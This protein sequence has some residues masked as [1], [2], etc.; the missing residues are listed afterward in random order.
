MPKDQSILVQPLSGHALALGNE[1]PLPNK[2]LGIDLCYEGMR[3]EIVQRGE[4]FRSQYLQV[5][6]QQEKGDRGSLP[7][8]ATSAAAT[9][10]ASAA[11]PTYT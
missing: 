11:V 4:M 3:S 6:T 8:A 7:A 10:A 9:A 2:G 5:D 1:H